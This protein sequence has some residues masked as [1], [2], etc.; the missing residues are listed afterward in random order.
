MELQN[1]ITG[2]PPLITVSF[3]KKYLHNWKLSSNKAVHE[4][5]YKITPFSE[6][7]NKTINWALSQ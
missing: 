1:H 2:I 7:V 5:G 3:V 4:L 6:G